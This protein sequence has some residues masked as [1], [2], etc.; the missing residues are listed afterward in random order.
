MGGVRGGVLVRDGA[1]VRDLERLH[2]LVRSDG[3]DAAVTDSKMLS[4]WINN[5]RCGIDVLYWVRKFPGLLDELEIIG[6]A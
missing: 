2:R 4:W 5:T 3:L 6:G 1:D